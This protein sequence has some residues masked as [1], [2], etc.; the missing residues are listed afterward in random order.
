MNKYLTLSFLILILVTLGSC[1][2][3]NSIDIASSFEENLQRY[4]ND[5][6]NPVNIR[7][8][9]K[10]TVGNIGGRVNWVEKK[11]RRLEEE[12]NKRKL[13]VKQ[14]EKQ[15]TKRPSNNRRQ[16]NQGDRHRRHKHCYYE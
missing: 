2:E 6:E 4:Q 11:R 13:L 1:E 15:A 9:R 3:N 14:P 5:I 8:K 10:S 16:G 12:K 7:E